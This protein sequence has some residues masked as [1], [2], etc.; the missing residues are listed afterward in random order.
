MRNVDKSW[1][2]L[3]SNPES[4]KRVWA[5]ICN[6]GDHNSDRQ[7]TGVY[8]HPSS[9]YLSLLILFNF[10]PKQISSITCYFFFAPLVSHRF[11]WALGKLQLLKEKVSDWLLKMK[12]KNLIFQ[13]LVCRSNEFLL[14]LWFSDYLADNWSIH[15]LLVSRSACKSIKRWKYKL[16]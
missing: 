4:L 10:F 7:G 8:T 16:I 2:K 14:F 12:E 11:L 9:H 1:L 5:V 15:K 13:H 3:S 6:T